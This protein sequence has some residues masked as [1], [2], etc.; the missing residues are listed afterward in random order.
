MKM[1][2]NERID[3]TLQLRAVDHSSPSD[4]VLLSDSVEWTAKDSEWKFGLDERS[5][6]C[7]ELGLLVDVDLDVLLEKGSALEVP[8]S[9]LGFWF[10]H[11]GDIPTEFESLDDLVG[12]KI[13]FE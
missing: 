2:I 6:K 13:S 8:L 4:R 9:V 11:K 5:D 10:G 3:P 1:S 7:A 12:I